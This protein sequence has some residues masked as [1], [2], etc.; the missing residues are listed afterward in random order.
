[1]VWRLFPGRFGDEGSFLPRLRRLA[2]VARSVLVLDEPPAG[3]PDGEFEP[4][5]VQTEVSGCSSCRRVIPTEFGDISGYYE[6]RGL[7]S[8]GHGEW[9]GFFWRSS[10]R[11]SQPEI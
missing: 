9:F 2:E 7:C 1:M 8:D 5:E 3:E 10:R 11:G 4:R 6:G